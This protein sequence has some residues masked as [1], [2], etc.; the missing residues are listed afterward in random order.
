MNI[1]TNMWDRYNTT[2]M[3]DKYNT[4]NM[5]DKYNTTNTW[6]KYNTKYCFSSDSSSSIVCFRKLTRNRLI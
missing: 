3:W 4:T 5:W 2:N 1:A 6:D